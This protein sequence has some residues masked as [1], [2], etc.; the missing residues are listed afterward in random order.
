MMSER[1]KQYRKAIR[2]LQAAVMKRDCEILRLRH[3]LQ[4]REDRIISLIKEN[5]RAWDEKMYWRDL[6]RSK[7]QTDETIWDMTLTEAR[8]SVA[9]DRD[10]QCCTQSGYECSA[11][12]RL[13]NTKLPTCNWCGKE[14]EK[15]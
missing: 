13:V 2:E 15:K 14:R 12:H 7:N 10:P 5:G 3:Q 8:A 4:F 6:C 9:L 1:H 11:C